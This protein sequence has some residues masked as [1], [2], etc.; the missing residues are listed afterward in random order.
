MGN[1]LFEKVEAQNE[2]L[3]QR[4]IREKSG[5]CERLHLVPGKL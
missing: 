2:A 3:C 1:V 4:D 5:E